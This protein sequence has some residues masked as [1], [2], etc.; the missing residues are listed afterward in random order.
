MCL[1]T[2]RV[3]A[4]L[5]AATLVIAACGGSDDATRKDAAT[6][7]PAQPAAAVPTTPAATSATAVATPSGPQR[8]EITVGEEGGSFYMRPSEA[9]VRPGAV[10]VALT[11]AG[12]MRPHNVVVRTRAGDSDLA[13]SATVE[14]GGATSLDF[15]VTEA[16]TY[17]IYCSLPGHKDRGARGTL[18]VQPS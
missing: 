2:T 4:V 8:I 16:G 1:T 13:K 14:P 17:E 5:L 12:P 7:A 9:T 18:T 10:T 11:N 3:A 15:S 6:S